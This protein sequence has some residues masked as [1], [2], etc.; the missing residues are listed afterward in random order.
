MLLLMISGSIFAQVKVGGNVYGGGKLGMVM[1]STVVTINGDTIEGSVYGGGMGIETDEM[2]G[3]V[4]IKTLVNMTGGH[5]KRSIYGGGE[6]A[7]VGTF[8]YDSITYTQ[9]THTG[10]KVAVPT[11]CTDNTG[12]A[13]VLVTGGSVGVKGSYMPYYGSDP[14]DDD[15]GWIFCGSKGLADS[16]TYYKAIG[17]GVVDSTYLEIS[18]NAL[19]TASV[20]G[21]CENGLVLHNT[22]VKIAGGQIGT[23]LRHKEMVNDVWTNYQW[24]GVY[25]D[26]LW[27]DAIDSIQKGTFTSAQA[28]KFRECDSWDYGDANGNFKI[29]DDFY[30]D[31]LNADDPNNIVLYLPEYT[32]SIGTNGHSFFGNVFGGGSGYYPIAPG[33]WR[34]MA[35]QVKGNTLVEITGGHILT[36]VYGGNEITDVIGKCTVN[37]S[38]GT[39]GVPCDSAT[40]VN[41]PVT[42]HL[43]GAG[44]G[45]PRVWAN[46]WTNV[47]ET[48]VTVSGGTIFGSVFGGGEDGHVLGN[49]VVNITDTVGSNPTLIG[50]LGYTY[51]EGNVFGGGRGFTGVALTAGGIGG[52]TEV[53]IEGGSILGSVFGGGRLAAVGNCFVPVGHE[54]YGHLQQDEN[55]VTHGYVTVNISGGTIGNKHESTLTHTKGGN[56]FGG[57]MGRITTL[58][59]EVNELWPYLARMKR[60]H[61]NISGGEIRSNVYGGGEYGS[62]FDS[63][64]VTITGGIVDRDVFGGGYGS[65][66][67]SMKGKYRPTGSSDTI[68]VMPMQYAGIV[69]GSTLVNIQGGWV[70]KSVYGGGELASVGTIDNDTTSAQYKHT[71]PTTQ[72]ALSWPYEFHYTA[73]TGNA[74]VVVTG[75]R[76]G[77]T[78]KDKMGNKG[79]DGKEIKEDNGDIYG[80]SKGLVGSNR[81]LMAHCANVNNA[82]ITITY[83]DDNTATPENYKDKPYNIGCITGAVYGGGENGHVN[84][85]TSIT[86]NNGL[87]GHALYGGGKGKD[88]YFTYKLKEN[89]TSEYDTIEN[90]SITAG[91]V[92]GNTH[93]HINDGYVVRSVFGGGNL[94]SVGKGNY[95]RD[96]YNTAGYGECST[97]TNDLAAA[98]ASGHTYI[99]IIGGQL[100][101]LDASDPSKVFKDNIP[102]GS[103]FGGCR[104]MA[105]EH[106]W[107]S[108]GFV[109]YTH[110][111]IG[112]LGDDN[113]KVHILGSVYGGS[114]DGHVRWDANTTVNS[115]EIGV[116][117]KGFVD[118][119]T[120]MGS[121]DL[122]TVYW[123]LRGNVFGGGSGAGTYDTYKLKANSTT[124]YDT[125]PAYSP[126]AGSVI[127]KTN[128][129][130][131]GGIIHRNVYG[132]GN[133]AS[134]GPPLIGNK[135][136]SIDSTNAT[137]NIFAPIGQNDTVGYGGNVFGGSRG[138]MDTAINLQNFAQVIYTKVK[139]DS[140]ID[141]VRPN[142]PYNVYG[143][144]ELGQVLQHTY[145]TLNK[146]VVNGEFF[147]GG[148]G[149]HSDS[150]Y[151]C[152]KGNT[153]VAIKG[154]QV[155]NNVYGGGEIASVG[156]V[157]TTGAPVDN[158]GFAQVTVSGGAIGNNIMYDTV[159]VLTKNNY[160]GHVFGGGKGNDTIAAYKNYCNVNQ[161]K[162]TVS[163]GKVWGSVFGG[164]AEGHVLG[165]DSVYITTG[166]IIGTKGT[167]EWDGQVFGGGKGNYK[168]YSAGRVGGNTCVTMD[169]GQILGNIYGGGCLSLV[170]IDS[171]DT[172][173]DGDD[174][175]NTKIRVQGGILGNNNKTN[176]NP[177]DEDEMVIEVYSTSSMGSIYGGGKGDIAG[178]DNHPAASALLLGL[179]KNTEVKISDSLG[180]NTHVYGIVF[181]GGEVANV[182]KYTWKIHPNYGVQNIQVTEGLAKVNISGGIIGG[183]RAKMRYQ[184]DDYYPIYPKYN[185]DLGYVY[186]GGEGISDNPKYYS[187]VDTTSLV[188]LVAT[189]NETQ[190][191]ISGG[192]VKGSVF[193]GAEAGHVRGDTW[194]T[195]K[196]GQIGAGDYPTKDS[197]Y[198]ENLFINPAT[199]PI[200]EQ[201]ALHG[202]T[203]WDF[204]KTVGSE[205][206][207]TPYDPV[208]AMVNIAP[209][210][211]KSWFGNV[212]GGG[213]GWFPYFDTIQ[214]SSK[215]DTIR[216]RW[217]PLC[218]KVWGNTHVV[219][220]GGHI[221]NNV[222]G[223]NEATDIGGN[224]YVEIK[225]GTVGVPRTSDQI[226]KQPCSGYVF[227]GGCG[228][229]RTV[230]DTITLVDSTNVIISGGI[231]YGSVYGGAEDGH[232]K[233]SASITI[234][235]TT[236]IGSTGTSTADGNIFGGGRNYLGE[237]NCAGRLE[238]NIAINVSSG[239]ILGSIFGGGFK[240]LSGVNV[241]G[242]F[243]TTNWTPADHGNVTINVSGDPN[244][245]NDYEQGV[246][247]LVDSDESVG[248]I[249][250]SG[251]GDTSNNIDT[252]AG[253]V[254]NTTINISGTPRINGSVFGGGEMA[255]VGWMNGNSYIPN[256]GATKITIDGNP[257]IGTYLELD[258]DYLDGT[259][260]IG[261]EPYYPSEW[262]IVETVD[263]AKR[264][265]HTCT[266]NVFG[267]CQGDANMEEMPNNW[268]YMARSHTD[269]VI[270]NGG[271]IM[272]DVYG[273]SEQGT[274]KGNTY[275]R[276]NGGTIGTEVTDSNNKKYNFGNAYGGGYG[277]D[278]PADN[279]ATFTMNGVST[280]ADSVAGRVYGNS[281]LD[282][283]YGTVLG[284]V[285]GGS[286][287]AYIGDAVGGSTGNVTLNIGCDTT[288]TGYT[289]GGNFYG[290]NN[291]DGAVFGDVDVNVKA[292][293]IGS[294]ANLNNYITSD[295]FGG[296]YGENTSTHGDV[297]VTV[298]TTGSAALTIYGD[299][300]GGSAYGSVNHD[301]SNKT[302]VN[303]LA[304]TL[305]SK[306]EN[307]TS[308]SGFDVYHGGNVYG[309]G[310][311]KTNDDALGV[312]VGE[313][314]VNIGETTTSGD[315]TTYSGKANIGGNIYGCNNTGGS[316][317]ENVTVNIYGTAQ[318]TGVNTFADE[319]YAIA[320][321]F[322]GGNF[323]NDTATKKKI[324]VNVFGCNNT[325][326]RLFGGG[327]AANT[328]GVTT[329]IQGGRFDQVFGG[330]N[331]ERGDS[332]AAD[333]YGDVNLGIHGGKVKYFFGGSNL[334][335]TIYNGSIYTT[336]DNNGPCGDSLNIDEYFCGGN[337]QDVIGNVI[338]TIDCHD[339][340]NV[341]SLYGG[342]NQ[343]DVLDDPATL[344]HEGNIHLIVQG[345]TFGKVF[346]GSKGRLANT[347][348][349]H[350][351][352]K[353]AIV[354]GDI[355]LEIQ[356]GTIDTVFGGNNVLGNVL[357]TI[358]VNMLDTVKDCPLIVHN[359]YGAGR[360]SIY[361]PD[362]VLVNGNKVPPIS[363]MVN[364]LH[365]TVSYDTINTDKGVIYTGGNVF[366]GG[367]GSS[368]TVTAN[369]K[370]T[371]G[372]KDH[373]ENVANI[374]GNVYGG[375]NAADV[376]GNTH[377]VLDGTSKVNL[378]GNVYGGGHEA[379]VEGNAKV[380]LKE[381]EQQP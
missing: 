56:V 63:A 61:V 248:D 242:E 179:V 215:R 205:V 328:P 202:T 353:P 73:G 2:A 299:V 64:V 195:I 272:G 294:Q 218:G 231:I 367:F 343:A 376:I 313:I 345:G 228:D 110:V 46:L 48:E 227:G 274:V 281:R 20:Y 302:I 361:A 33:V 38:G 41:H 331:G 369:P 28:A 258:K 104:G 62:V 90:Y 167:T 208:L 206:V 276:I 149:H 3:L 40:L 265:V 230:F 335:G 35:G 320:N 237:N 86:L 244:I 157:S 60:S 26:S 117:F 246:H 102:Y 216:S 260:V 362:S 7:S 371:I 137:V 125:I 286:A 97:N 144:G 32:D 154:G 262:T 186:G 183:D 121:I 170:G 315:E 259:L 336:V 65:D 31:T 273:G 98:A 268:F 54:Q 75:G 105:S 175:G 194:V 172:M 135:Y 355:L 332:Y 182:G 187:K 109:N 128:V 363:P 243:P 235:G 366:G 295:V 255:S 360:N 55:G 58:K 324:Y 372:D 368:A 365:G 133:I 155:K 304:G 348:P 256:T 338:A 101:A 84:D 333:I 47:K 350:P 118:A 239:N 106:E 193:G 330:G 309:G 126:I 225:G 301:G 209:S 303:I 147:G 236:V 71:D 285:F 36:S 15:R 269:T 341:G 116:N 340:M 74:N 380:E 143:G 318:E 211:G 185:D 103:V 296:G 85:S 212:F 141:Y 91:K 374:H 42:C 316:P 150:S 354:Q 146:G 290:A 352:A 250:G 134:V 210:D 266:G 277:S 6:L 346:G 107:D 287:F 8:T 370:V 43:F 207:Y 72:L 49:T 322:G 198:R 327:D 95:N 165:N 232:V 69:K 263:G 337:L 291:R 83:P 99:D 29:Y 317:Q 119:D 233:G 34:R 288:T 115:G 108:F 314:E 5:V 323:A 148:K 300:Y 12:L 50:T 68:Q 305:V 164:S 241:N 180:K 138:V 44:M 136:C 81:Y 166:A 261:G 13:K 197:L 14:D 278:D 156:Q 70:K 351:D 329:D 253:C 66:S 139:L 168:K 196:G 312:V 87:I 112:K 222:Y 251:K 234:N 307:V 17:L 325:I 292:G 114:Q 124:E 357:G 80:G 127:Q 22:H 321:V 39:I 284:S 79:S 219:V 189:V 181:G 142:V 191:T 4:K 213:S 160:G 10:K 310:L 171:N 347:D 319:G 226:K 161:T 373:P 51:V 184:K 89:S 92:Y 377:V 271:T 159:E 249:F 297:T 132:G 140:V 93:V 130:I 152:V 342:C 358:T 23:G 326:K 282:I 11:T 252:L 111:T 57:S 204:G 224:S 257:T 25:S 76:I 378:N 254:T 53:N 163:R 339:G 37:M 270:I 223:A 192:W 220:E 21:G 120:V 188:N 113:D 359:I 375:G 190:V 240:A 100:G 289:V 177:E 16:I 45:D 264:V 221:L 88:T 349:D 279:V 200:T 217:N 214:L 283:N 9:G 82:V 174:H 334:H 203:H 238:G 19:V 122:D 94:A 77:I 169:D 308:K 275:V 306:V 1:D 293:T 178:L 379:K 131:N 298:D 27:Q 176:T 201:T 123:T 229:P 18:G 78:G 344:E 381:P 280:T 153:Y 267:G 67:I 151:A 52:N 129:T 24:D 145:D 30:G 59:N 96:S 247:L 311:G 356:G 162:V 245:G 173:Q 158:T 199:T 364:I